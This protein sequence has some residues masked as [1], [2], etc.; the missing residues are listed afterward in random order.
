MATMTETLTAEEARERGLL[1]VADVCQILGVRRA[2]V[3]QLV[4][5]GRLRPLLVHDRGANFKWAFDRD[6]VDNY[7]AR[8]WRR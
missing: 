2:R 5:E 8:R 4:G 6:D 1:F 3:S 7:G